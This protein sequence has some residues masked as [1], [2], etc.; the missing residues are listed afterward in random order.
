MRIPRI[1][2][3]LVVSVI[4]GAVAGCATITTQTPAEKATA[5]MAAYQSA[6]EAGDIEMMMAA[7]SEDFSNQ[8]GWT[9]ANL[10]SYFQEQLIPG[11]E[12]SVEKCDIAVEGDVATAMVVYGG[13]LGPSA[14]RLKLKEEADGVWRIFNGEQM[15]VP[16][17]SA[18]SSDIQLAIDTL[19]GKRGS[20]YLFDRAKASD[21]AELI[22]SG[23]YGR[24]HSLIIL[25]D[26]EILIEE[27]FRGWRRDHL[28]QIFS[29]TKS[30]ASALT[31]IAI[32]QGLIQGTG[33]KLKDIF[34][35]YESLEN[36]D[37]RKEA[38]TLGNV[39]SMTAGYRWNENRAPYKNSDGSWN[40]N[41]DIVKMSMNAQDD[42]KY[43]LDLPLVDDPGTKF[44]YN[45]GC[46]ILLS[47]IIERR[48][49]KSAE[50][51]AA[52][53]LF[54]P[55]GIDTWFWA[56]TPRGTTD[57]GGG[58]FL[59]PADMALFGYLFL[60]NGKVGERQII[61]SGWVQEST[62]KQID[63][64]GRGGGYGYQWWRFPDN[65]GWGDDAKDTP[66]YAVG[67][68]GQVI[69][70]IPRANM[71]VVSTGDN[72][73]HRGKNIFSFLYEHILPALTDKS[74]KGLALPRRPS[75]GTVTQVLDA[76]EY[77][78]KEIKL[79]AF[80]RADV[81]DSGSQGQLWLRV[82]REGGQ[83]GL[84]DNMHDRPIQSSEWHPYEIIGTVAGDATRIAFGCFLQGTGR[85]WVDG[86]QLFVKDE[87]ED[88]TAIQVQNPGFE[89]EAEGKPKIW[90]AA[91]PG[92]VYR[93][94]SENPH[95][96]ERSLLITHKE[97]SS[98]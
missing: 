30:V 33:L 1:T 53:N 83:V 3:V 78:G 76:G 17:V 87:D 61:S 57:T 29:S 44:T 36:M 72:L 67:I 59:Y 95:E 69:F 38:L 63:I 86:F 66:Y 90:S 32:D 2:V 54:K 58:L 16:V 8:L 55:L 41:N 6:L 64:S 47:G 4:A 94:I 91:S 24:I 20:E 22:R 13:T 35:E 48:T 75:F 31:G 28:H 42:M 10:R 39:L 79:K 49:G 92:Y 74:G 37:Q 71:V 84:F 89:E 73:L 14:N 81:S 27:Y 82:D 46:S 45:S 19:S 85:V 23:E 34:T 9:K 51:Y 5:A 21:A 12:R 25:Q 7:F 43:V 77:R 97:E 88:W 70:V 18:G 50:E 93:V 80:V 98:N 68:G 52:A 62:A 56:K 96:G 65:M 60:N 26:S 40:P 15:D 11:M